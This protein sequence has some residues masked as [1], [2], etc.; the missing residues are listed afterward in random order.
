MVGN[1]VFNSPFGDLMKDDA[2]IHAPFQCEVR[3]LLSN[4]F[5]FAVVIDSE[6]YM[7]VIGSLFFNELHGRLLAIEVYPLPIVLTI[8]VN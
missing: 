1:S 3:N 5:P 6:E 7:G 8:F 4:G 2:S